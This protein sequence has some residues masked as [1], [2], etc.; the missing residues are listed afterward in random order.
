MIYMGWKTI[1]N[2]IHYFEV[3]GQV[4]AFGFPFLIS[5]YMLVSA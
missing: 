1:W 4:F 2:I 3:C 5:V